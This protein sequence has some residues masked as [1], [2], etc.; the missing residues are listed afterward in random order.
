MLSLFYISEPAVDF[1]S[2]HFIIIFILKNELQ[3]ALLW[4][5][6]YKLQIHNYLTR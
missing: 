2:I 1:E 3:L 6:C 4:F 5:K